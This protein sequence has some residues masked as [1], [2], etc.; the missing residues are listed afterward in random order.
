MCLNQVVSNFVELINELII[1]FV[2]VKNRDIYLIDLITKTL[3]F[4]IQ[5][6]LN[7]RLKLFLDNKY[8]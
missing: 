6:F 8:I 5:S 2:V 3:M 7:F 1:C 4:A